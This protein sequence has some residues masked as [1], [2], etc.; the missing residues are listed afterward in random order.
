MTL[1]MNVRYLIT[2]F[3]EEEKPKMKFAPKPPAKQHK[4]SFD[5]DLDF[6]SVKSEKSEKA[7][8]SP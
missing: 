5:K 3:W 6:G 1:Q 2:A 4:E 8:K 7:L